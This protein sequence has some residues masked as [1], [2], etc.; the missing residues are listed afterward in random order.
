MDAE[1]STSASNVRSSLTDD[2][3]LGG[4]VRLRQPAHGYRAGADAMLLAA[5]VQASAGARLM[6][7]GCGAGA[8]LLAAAARWPQA[9]FLGVER[10]AAM[11]A[12][13]REN[14]ARNAM[15]AWVRVEEGDA[16]TPGET[17]DGVFCNPP[18][19]H[20]GE[21][22]APHPARR[23][24]YLTEAPI[25]AWIAALANRLTG[26]A[27]LTL[28][29]RAE[30][31]GALL[32]ALEGRLGGVEIYPLRPRA[33]QPAKRILIRAR[34]GARAKPALL[35]G[36]DLHDGSGAKFTPE[37]DAIFRGDAAIPW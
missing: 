34:K 31:L 23:A 8:A 22:Q 6:E 27:A 5:A 16:L 18:F 21:A 7:A 25:D 13:A 11:A 36:L 2:A 4:R 1:S 10:D 37:A 19:D 24:A 29:Q 32:A 35:K 12:L 33:D 26:G 14:V 28:I 3:F 30:H 15:D 9:H 17:F 20:E